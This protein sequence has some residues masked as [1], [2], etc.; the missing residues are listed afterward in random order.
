MGA[1]YFYHLT[2]QSLDEALPMLLSRSLQNGWRVT[3]RGMRAPMLE[4]LDQRLWQR[5]RPEDFLPHGMAGGEHDARQPILL[6]TGAGVP[7]DAQCLMAVDAADVSV[8]EVNG[9]E[10][11][12]IIFDGND[13]DQLTHARGQWK[14]LTDSGCSAQYW[15]QEGGGWQKKAEK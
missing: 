15:S 1:A 3:V 8:D 4:H 12:C 5:G 10:R 2:R 14:A 7:N 13:H 9:L 11:V 6:T